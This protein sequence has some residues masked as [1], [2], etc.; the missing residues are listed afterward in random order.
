METVWF[1]EM[2]VSTYESARRHNP[3]DQH[4]HSHRRENLRSHQLVIIIIGLKMYHKIT[5]KYEISGSHGGDYEDDSLLGSC[6]V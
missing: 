6:V 5:T 2:L 4:R 1:S 3:E